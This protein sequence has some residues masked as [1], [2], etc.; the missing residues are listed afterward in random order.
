VQKI[1]QKSFACF[2]A[3]ITSS[4]NREVNFVSGK[5]KDHGQCLTED[6]LTDYLEG[7]LDPA[8]KAASEVHLIACDECRSQLGFFMRLMDKDV[9][10]EEAAEIEAISAQWDRYKISNKAP[11]RFGA[12]KSWLRVFAAVAATLLISFISIHFVLDRSAEPKSASEVVQLLLSQQRPFE[13]RL[14]N[15][16]HLPIVHTRGENEP[17]VS[18]GLLAG[19][20]TRL[21]ADSYQMGRFYLI[22][23]DFDRAIRY[24]EMAEREVGA[25]ADVHNDLGVAYIESGDES[26]I[27]KAAREF[28]HALDLD[29]AS[30]AAVFNLAIYYER[31]A[32]TQ[33]ESQWKRYLELDANSPWA[34]EGRSRLQ[35]LSR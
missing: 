9:R 1:F 7:A 3:R 35:G 24:L 8:V 14:S 16:P 10:P 21:S 30:V 20:M 27:Q 13:F 34:M 31:A 17:G 26:R 4:S 28:Q 23:K 12:L 19:E 33:V 22:Q 25:R 18:Y 6:T 5:T 29:P 32:V 15:E 2:H 11:R